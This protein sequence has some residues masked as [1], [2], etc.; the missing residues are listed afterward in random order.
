MYTF[1]LTALF[2]MSSSSQQYVMIQSTEQYD[3]N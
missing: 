2:V 1:K 3:A